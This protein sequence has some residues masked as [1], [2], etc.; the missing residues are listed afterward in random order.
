[1]SRYINSIKLTRFNKFSDDIALLILE[2]RNQDHIRK[3]MIND[4][5]IKINDHINWLKNNI[6]DK[7][8]IFYLIYIKKKI[9]GLIRFIIKDKDA[10]WSFYLDKN[11]KNIYGAY[12]EYLAIEKI[13][14]LKKIDK[15]RCQVLSNNIRIV[16][17]HKKFG[18]IENK[19]EK[20]FLYRKSMHLDL[21]F[22][23]NDKKSW[24]I[25]KM[26]IKNKLKC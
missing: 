5:I 16:S 8:N 22:L 1:M 18:F 19:I 13:F 17:L 6:A 20:K 26:E 21:F 24:T 7:K 4:K 23:E 3:N 12:V 11:C 15:L 10:D 2:I 14:R 25:K 9:A